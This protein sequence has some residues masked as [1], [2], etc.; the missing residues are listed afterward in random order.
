VKYKKILK[1]TPP[2]VIHSG[3]EF[4]RYAVPPKRRILVASMPRC[5]STLLIRAIGG[6]GVGSTM[7]KSSSC[8]FV[9]NLQSLPPIPILK[10]HSV[11]PKY[12]PSDVKTIFLFGNPYSAAWSMWKKRWDRESFKNCGYYQDDSPQIFSRDALGLE[13]IFDSWCD[14]QAPQ[15]LAVR[16]ESL[17]ENKQIIESFLEK[18]IELPSFAERNTEVP[19]SK[20]SSL[21]RVYGP[22]RH[23]I[24]TAPD[25]FFVNDKGLPCSF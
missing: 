9:R 20:L 1:K 10:T 14:V 3:Y 21:Q 11:A 12:L 18:R 5:G 13:R 16:F 23:K 24:D 15:V 25:I 22:L 8:R 19:G 6:F 17:W 2:F 7:P 4:V